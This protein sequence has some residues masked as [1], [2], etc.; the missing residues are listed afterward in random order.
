MAKENSTRL[1]RSTLAANLHR[2]VALRYFVMAGCLMLLAA[3]LTGFDLVVATPAAWASL[4]LYA[5]ANFGVSVLLRRRDQVGEPLFLANLALDLVFLFVFLHQTGGSSN[6]FTLLFLLPVIVAAATLRPASI[7]V[8]TALSIGA[9][10][11]LLWRSPQPRVHSS[12]QPEFDL[13][14]LGMWLGLVFI[15]GLVAYFVTWMGR[16]LR[17][18]ERALA[19]ARERALRDERVI[20]LGAIAAGAAH[21]LGTPLSTIAVLLREMEKGHDELDPL[22]RK[23]M[24]LLRDQV[25][26][27]K[28]VLSG[29]SAH[30]HETRAEAGQRLKPAEFLQT[31]VARWRAYR[32][33]VNIEMAWQGPEPDATLVVDL[34]L[35]Q[36]IGSLLNNAA[37]ASPET[38]VVNGRH[39][40]HWLAIEIEDRGEGMSEQVARSLGKRPVSTKQHD[41]GMGIGMMLAHSVIDRLGGRVELLSSDSAGTRVRVLLPIDELRV[42]A[43][44]RTDEPVPEAK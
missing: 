12:G 5:A 1:W 29:L 20:A 15:A 35:F 11:L 44:G 13:H 24:G 43:T 37:D 38:I 31:L 4:L 8:V 25:D 9:Y 34:T 23:R 30:G 19:E 28:S 2:L 27:C 3:S 16:A 36:A 17:D 6:P 21:E 41:N 32:P 39:D 7:W 33:E 22:M 42:E 26:R 40:G 14:I 10:T 18:R